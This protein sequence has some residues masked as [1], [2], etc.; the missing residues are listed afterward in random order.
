MVIPVETGNNMAIILTEKQR[1][2]AIDICDR[3]EALNEKLQSHANE[4][5]K[6]IDSLPK[7]PRTKYIMDALTHRVITSRTVA[8]TDPFNGDWITE[9]IA[10]AFE[11][12][13]DDVECVESEDGEFYVIAGER[14][15]FVECN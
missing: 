12:S 3:L 9:A 11:V 15:A 4:I 8:L 6:I 5:L 10:S 13:P 14:V 2:E 7:G 1:L